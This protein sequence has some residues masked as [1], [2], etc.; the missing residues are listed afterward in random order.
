MTTFLVVLI[1][2]L[3]GGA[4]VAGFAFALVV[5]LIVGTYSS[6]FI[7]SPIVVDTTN[8]VSAL[9]YDEEEDDEFMNK[10]DGDGE[11]LVEDTTDETKA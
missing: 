7:A 10:E 1:L 9:K 8:D 6:I 3:F 5:G 11:E 2:F 4:G